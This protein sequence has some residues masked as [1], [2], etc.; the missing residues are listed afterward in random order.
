MIGTARQ[1]GP[2]INA[3]PPCAPGG[4]RVP[5]K[6]FRQHNIAPPAPPRSAGPAERSLIGVFLAFQPRQIRC[7]LVEII[8]KRLWPDGPT[9]SLWLVGTGRIQKDSIAP[10]TGADR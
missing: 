4:C 1:H 9:A 7:G 8:A 3:R 5:V 6:V 10:K 2:L